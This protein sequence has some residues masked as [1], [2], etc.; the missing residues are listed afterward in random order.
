MTES[1]I[2]SR[3]V[4]YRT[5]GHGHGPITRLMSPGDLGQHLKPFVFLDIVQID[6]MANT[7][8]MGLHPHSGIAT[9]TVFAK[10]NMRFDDGE[11]H[12]G[13]LGYGAVEWMRAGRGVWH[14]QEMAPGTSRGV[15][16]FQLWLALPP[17]LE[18]G[19]PDGQ[20]IEAT[21]MP[22]AGPERLI[23]GQYNG[24]TSPVRAPAGINYLMVTLQPGQTWRYDTPVGHTV[25]WMAVALGQ[26]SIDDRID[27]GEMA[28]LD[29]SDG[30]IVLQA[31]GSQETVFIVGTAVPHS[32]PLHLGNYSVH[33]SRESLAIGEAHIMD[34]RQK[35][36]AREA[37]LQRTGPVPVLK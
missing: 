13:I 33:T 9:V 21:D 8:R 12:S 6:D 27:A 34:L 10:G 4:V 31:T 18:I 26:V 32:H 5:R 24:M 36:I 7:P 30:P 35:L 1:S 22:A 28:V 19:T 20:F 2:L 16:G 15:V 14:G 23:L 17:E 29:A 11:G 3:K 25:G 37:G